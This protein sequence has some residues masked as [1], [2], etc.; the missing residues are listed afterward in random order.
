MTPCAIARSNRCSRKGL[1][2]MDAIGF[3]S[4]SGIA[5]RNRLPKP[6]ASTTS[7][8]GDSLFSSLPTAFS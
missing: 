8:I 5:P 1:P 4:P 2:A 6:P 7:C 3:G